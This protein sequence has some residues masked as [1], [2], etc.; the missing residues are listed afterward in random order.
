ME[1]YNN[2]RIP[3]TGDFKD[4]FCHFY[5]AENKTRNPIIKTLVPSYQTIMIFSFGN[6]VLLHTQQD[7]TLALSKCIVLGPVKFAFKYTLQVNSEILV[8]NFKDDAFYRFFSKVM[9]NSNSLTHPDTLLESNCFALLWTHLNEI[10]DNNSRVE[11][12]LEFCKPYLDEQSAI[13]NQLN[14]IDNETL[15]PIKTIA[16]LNNESERNIQIKHKK[17]LGYS[18]KEILRF[19]RFLKVMEYIPKN[20]DENAPQIDWLDIVQRCGYYD[21]SHLI[22]DFKKYLNM[23]PTKY[24]RFQQDICYPR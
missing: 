15:N 20:I 19:E 5:F 9:L 12:I 23:S 7:E 18:A 13:A 21:Q 11:F 17:Y 4:V 10:K 8:A 24:L 14:K 6:D 16:E 3:V 2:Y 22:H 1:N